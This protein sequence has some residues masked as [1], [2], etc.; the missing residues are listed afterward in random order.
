[1]NAVLAKARSSSRCAVD[2]LNHS[3]AGKARG[4]RT[5]RRRRAAGGRLAA[6]TAVDDD[7]PYGAFAPTRGQKALIGLIRGSFLHHGE[8]RKRLV[9][10]IGRLRAGPI[11]AGFRGGRFR[12][13]YRDNLA[14]SGMLLHPGFNREELDFLIARTPVGGTF[15][16]L[17]ANVG[18]YSIPL[19]RHVGAAGRVV[20]V[21]PNPQAL[22]R[23]RANIALSGAGNIIVLP[24]AVG[25][26]AGRVD[27]HKRKGDLAI[28]YVEEKAD[29]ALAMK[30]LTELL[31]EAGV[32]RADTLKADIEGHEFK[33]L[34]PYLAATARNAW[35]RAM[36]IEPGH[37]RA[38]P[39][40]IRLLHDSGYATVARTRRNSLLALG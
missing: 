20:A 39:D 33:A 1:M 35:P 21:E 32:A 24:Y 11:D 31:R 30:P 19:S 15:V 6:G 27:L 2:A 9:P 8:F 5:L 12:L 29:G 10:L 25:E 13:N 34:A 22:V 14:E 36:V 37:Y 7:A 38:L 26:A 18:L 3:A 40:S 16:D 17:G 28:V 4:R 23:L